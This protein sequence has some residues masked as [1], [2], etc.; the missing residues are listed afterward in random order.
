M[1]TH[2][3]IK[4]W[5][6][7]NVNNQS[8][9]QSS[10]K[11]LHESWLG[12]ISI[13]IE[14]KKC[15]IVRANILFGFT[16]LNCTTNTTSRLL[17]Q[18]VGGESSWQRL[19]RRVVSPPPPVQA[20]QS[21]LTP[22]PR[23]ASNLWLRLLWLFKI[24]LRAALCVTPLRWSRVEPLIVARSSWQGFFFSSSKPRPSN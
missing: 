16:C 24:R 13:H 10:E 7:P 3:K 5:L 8:K 22:P 14:M 18:R 23:L 12:C 6:Q 21:E 4:A 11:I 17:C 1:S 2:F 15:Q 9:Y 19:G 20:L